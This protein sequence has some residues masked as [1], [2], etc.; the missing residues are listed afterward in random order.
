MRKIVFESLNEVISFTRGEDA[1]STIGIGQKTLIKKWLDE[2]EITDYKINSDLSIDVE[3]H[4][5]LHNKGLIEFPKFIKFNHISG[6]FFCSYNNLTSLKG[7]PASVDG[8]FDCSYNNLTSLEGCPKFVGGSY[9][10]NNNKLQFT[11][12]DVRKLCNVEGKITV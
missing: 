11:E 9:Y 1:L 12:E 5:T 2:M 3:G 6:D 4:V 10:C 7:C 8:F